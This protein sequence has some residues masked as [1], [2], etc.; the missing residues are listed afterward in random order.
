MITAVPMLAISRTFISA[1]IYLKQGKYPLAIFHL[2]DFSQA[3]FLVQARAYSLMGDAY[4][5]QKDFENAAKYY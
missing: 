5:E 1:A 4:M 2:E 3:I